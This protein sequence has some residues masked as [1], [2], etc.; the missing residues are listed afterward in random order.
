[1]NEPAKHSLTLAGLFVA[2]TGA[3]LF[4]TKAIIVKKAF[5]ATQVDA[6]S[7][8]TL[9]MAF[10]LPFYLGA[11]YF[12]SRHT[13]NVK[14]TK[15]QWCL[16]F[17][18]GITGYYLSSLFDFLGLQYISAGLERLILFLYPTFAVLLNYFI[19]KQAIQ[20]NQWI[21]LV[22][23][24]LGIG[25]ALSGE[26]R[27]NAADEKLLW[28][29][30]LV[31]VCA[32]T[33]SFYIVGSGKIIPSIGAAKFTAY[34]MLSAT[35]GVFAHFLIKGNYTQLAQIDSLLTYGFLLAV[36]ATV[37]PSFLISNAMKR[38]GS[39]N[40]AIISSIGPVSTIL[41]AHFFLGEKIFPEQIAGTVLVILGVLLLGWKQNE[42]G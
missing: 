33:Y 5:A 24:Y 35:I 22:L 14:M 30:F 2:L 7:L 3:I 27:I 34:A 21:A 17:L 42:T 9:R 16:T 37:V 31:F 36:L 10:S 15:R 12:I 1:M 38:I 18:V 23:T 11:A 8:L 13:G 41:Q 20:K 26:I 40:V 25:L 29:S 39:S 6:V 32:V 4:S 28:G 19:F